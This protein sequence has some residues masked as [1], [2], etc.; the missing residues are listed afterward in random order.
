MAQAA[1]D[2][3]EEGSS[4]SNISI[5]ASITDNRL[6]GDGLPIESIGRTAHQRWIDREYEESIE[7]DRSLDALCNSDPVLPSTISPSPSTIPPFEV[8][9]GTDWGPSNLGSTESVDPIPEALTN[10][11]RRDLASMEESSETSE[12]QVNPEIQYISPFI[13]DQGP[14][15]TD[16]PLRRLLEAEALVRTERLAEAANEGSD[17]QAQIDDE[18]RIELDRMLDTFEE[19]GITDG[20]E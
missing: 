20:G 6:D 8:P 10:E 17:R 2:Q 5:S 7:L 18:S 3:L 12:T 9:H 19:E 14:V 13:S 16:G 1:L 15:L 4:T 11:I